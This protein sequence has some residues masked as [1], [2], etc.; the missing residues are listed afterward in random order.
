MGVDE[1][2]L[3]LVRTEAD[4]A[5]ATPDGEEPGLLARID[6]LHRELHALATRVDELVHRL[7]AGPEQGTAA[8]P[9]R[10]TRP[11]KESAQPGGVR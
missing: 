8:S 1:R 2:I 5:R 11:G 6:D 3:H 9:V 7:E 4:K 10:R